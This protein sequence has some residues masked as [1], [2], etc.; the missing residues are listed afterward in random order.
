MDG[1]QAAVVDVGVNLS[2]ADAGVA[3]HFLQSSDVSTTGQ[4]MT[5][6]A[7]GPAPVEGG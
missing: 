5:L 6:M 3:Q 4:Q 1:F 7:N 2:C